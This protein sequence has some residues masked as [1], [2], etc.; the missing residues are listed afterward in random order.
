M[1]PVLLAGTWVHGG[2]LA[3]QLPSTYST[4]DGFPAPRITLPDV[5]QVGDRPMG[6]PLGKKTAGAGEKGAAVSLTTLRAPK[7]AQ[8]AYRAGLVAMSARRW[9]EAEAKLSKAVAI[10][11]PYAPA[12]GALGSVFEQEHE[13]DL[14]LAAFRKSILVDRSYIPGYVS[15]AKQAV[16]QHQWADALQFST[17]AIRLHPIELPV[18]WLYGAIAALRLRQW[19]L[20]ET[21]AAMAIQQDA[22][23][24][25]LA[26]LVLAEALDEQGKR[27]DAV[28]HYRRYLDLTPHASQEALVTQRLMAL[29][30]P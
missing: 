14:A 7:N 12:W 6:P 30:T 13:P 17:A 4:P 21:D 22:A 16:F 23:V 11:P 3:A 24:Y 20:A 2:R 9:S 27:A 5:S 15:L 26:E 18:V 29:R 10:Y 8:R 1:L 19:D 25:S 28:A